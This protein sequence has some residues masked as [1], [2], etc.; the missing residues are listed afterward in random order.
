MT[1]K[2]TKEQENDIDNLR[3]NQLSKYM[4]NMIT[5]SGGE[6]K[7]QKRKR[8]NKSKSN[9]QAHEEMRLSKEFFSLNPKLRSEKGM[10]KKSKKRIDEKSEKVVDEKPEKGGVEKLEKGVVQKSPSPISD[11][12]GVINYP[13]E[14]CKPFCTWTLSPSGIQ[15]GTMKQERKKV[16]R[17]HLQKQQG[18]SGMESGAEG[19]L[20]NLEIFSEL[21]KK[22][23]KE[24]RKKC[25]AFLSEDDSQAVASSETMI[26][27]FPLRSLY[28]KKD[29]IDKVEFEYAELPSGTPYPS[30][31]LWTWRGKQFVDEIFSSNE[32]LELEEN[33]FSVPKVQPQDQEKELVDDFVF[34]RR[35][36]LMQQK[37]DKGIFKD[38][39]TM[40]GESGTESN[41]HEDYLLLSIDDIEVGNEDKTSDD[42]VSGKLNEADEARTEMYYETTVQ[43]S[44]KPEMLI[45]NSKKKLQKIVV[46]HDELEGES[47]AAV[48]KKGKSS[49]KYCS[50]YE[51]SPTI[52]LLVTEDS[53]DRENISRSIHYKPVVDLKSGKPWNGSGEDYC[54]YVLFDF[55]FLSVLCLYII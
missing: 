7:L 1:H 54:K 25:R 44:L 9:P 14:T 33:S 49:P 8:E 24:V 55:F 48:V 27:T 23:K 12:F 51:D 17:S 5:F 30:Q 31:P 29:S 46:N 28:L 45:T 4:L 53:P 18:P 15:E 34:V 11:Q 2:P 40:R 21:N 32:E 36:E 10:D 19:L 39:F 37:E 43:H 35:E 16:N 6:V 50:E 3:G 13:P 47:N 38:L 41:I 52:Q 42:I 22:Q 26:P 20:K